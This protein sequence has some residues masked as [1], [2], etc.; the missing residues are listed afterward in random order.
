[1]AAHRARHAANNNAL[2]AAFERLV[3]GGLTDLHYVDGQRLWGD[4]G[5]ATSY[6]GHPSDLGMM[7]TVE[8]LE[9]V[10]RPLMTRMAAGRPT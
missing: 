6:G 7:R 3:Q 8:V 1:V 4:D 10:L 2:R 9:P 5:E